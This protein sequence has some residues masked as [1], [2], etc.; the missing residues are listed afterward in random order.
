[1]KKANLTLILTVLLSATFASPSYAGDDEWSDAGKVMAIMEGVRVL[2]GGGVDIIGSVTG[3]K[4]PRS[5]VKH[6]IHHYEAPRPV[7]KKVWV[8][9]YSWKKV[10]VDE[11]EE[12]HPEYGKVIVEPHYIKY[13]TQ[14]GGYWDYEPVTV[15][16]TEDDY[17]LDRILRKAEKV[18]MKLGRYLGSKRHFAYRFNDN[19]RRDALGKFNALKAQ[20]YTLLSKAAAIDH[21]DPRLIALAKWGNKTKVIYP[22]ES[23]FG[24]PII[25]DRDYRDLI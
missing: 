13:R 22:G 23:K 2:T 25:S 6:H 11:H 20:Y 8:P 14:S 24:E 1:M 17:E 3:I 18:Q 15:V 9:T 7:R 12:Y 10:H 19:G 21:N 5:N 4:Q 16:E